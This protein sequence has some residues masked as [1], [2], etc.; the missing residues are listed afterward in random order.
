MHGTSYGSLYLPRF[1]RRSIE[2][3]EFTDNTL[4]NLNNT[5]GKK[6]Y[7]VGVQA[8]YLSLLVRHA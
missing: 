8:E 5:C 2:P 6:N 4:I 3:L 1:F 7:A